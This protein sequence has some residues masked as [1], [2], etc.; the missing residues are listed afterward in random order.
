MGIL[1]VLSISMR[2]N[3]RADTVEHLFRK[4]VNSWGWPS[5]VRSDKGGENV[6]VARAMLNAQG[7]RQHIFNVLNV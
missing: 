4:A 2:H 5:R 6:N 3:N 7:T 1:D